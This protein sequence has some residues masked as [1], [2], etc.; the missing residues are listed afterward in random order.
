MPSKELT[1]AEQLEGKGIGHL[2]EEEYP[3]RFVGF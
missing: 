3:Y 1:T 2:V